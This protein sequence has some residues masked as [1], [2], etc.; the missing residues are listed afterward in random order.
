MLTRSG[1]KLLDFGL[2]KMTGPVMSEIQTIGLTAAGSSSTGDNEPQ[3]LVGTGR[4]E[5]GW[6]SG[7]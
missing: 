4:F 1:A 3:S 7:F 6:I 2:A 5:S